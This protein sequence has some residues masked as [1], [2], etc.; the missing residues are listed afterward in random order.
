ME[1]EGYFDAALA[2]QIS[3]SK[4]F[5]FFDSPLGKQLIS[6]ETILREFKFSIL[7]NAEKYMDGL[8]GEEVLL[9]GV[10][11]CAFIEDGQITVIDFKTDR[12]NDNTIESVAHGY[13][14]QVNAYAH[15]LGRIFQ[16]PIQ[17]AYLYFFETNSLISVI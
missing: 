13:F 9:Q 10:V 2:L 15:S 4:L 6:A 12:V 16:M 14:P 7:D 3:A 8:D 11:D 1:A 17:N 5:H